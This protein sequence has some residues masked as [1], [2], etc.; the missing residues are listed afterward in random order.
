MAKCF[1]LYFKHPQ[2]INTEDDVNQAAQSCINLCPSDETSAFCDE[3]RKLP[4]IRA[5]QEDQEKIHL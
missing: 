4:E 2:P 1:Q 5:I 3:V